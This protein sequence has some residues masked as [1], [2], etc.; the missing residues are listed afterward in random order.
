MP[1]RKKARAAQESLIGDRIILRPFRKNDLSCVLKWSR[2]PEIRKLTGEA[3][4]MSRA[5]AEGWYRRMRADKDRIWY[6]IVLKEDGRMIGECGL[7]RMFRPWRCT[8][9][10]II[11]GDK[12]AWGVGYGT[13]AARLVLDLAFKKLGFHRISIGVVGFNE[14]ALRFWKCLGFKKEGIQRDG[15]YCDGRHSDFVMMSVLEDEY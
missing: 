3:A 11:I 6:A 13:E 4:P 5:E 15:Y 7:L 2:D 12:G 1:P 8:D 9:M 14:R 10:T